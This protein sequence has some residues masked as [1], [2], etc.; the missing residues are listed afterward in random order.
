MEFENVSQMISK[1]FCETISDFNDLSQNDKVL[2]FNRN[3]IPISDF[4]YYLRYVESEATKCFE[5]ELNMFESIPNRWDLHEIS[6]MFRNENGELKTVMTKLTYDNF[7]HSP[8]ATS[9][10]DEIEHKKLAENI[11]KEAKE[12]FAFDHDMMAWSLLSYVLLFSCDL[13]ALEEP[14]K[15]YKIQKVFHRL[16]F[17]YL[18]SKYK[19]SLDY[20]VNP[21]LL[22]LLRKA[23]RLKFEKRLQV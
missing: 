18:K 12:M 21:V 11:A 8:W 23:N 19:I 4:P 10:E 15:V 1:F 3:L 20:G 16:L 6:Q 17:V 5:A 14:Q 2:I 9:I 22:P 13:E 7:F